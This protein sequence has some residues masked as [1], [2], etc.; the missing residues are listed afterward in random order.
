MGTAELWKKKESQ[1]KSLVMV[2][3]TVHEWM[4]MKRTKASGKYEGR[5][6][7]WSEILLQGIY[8]K[9]NDNFCTWELKH[10]KKS[11]K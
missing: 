8:T 6:E 11:K 7:K 10:I 9:D 4:L 2:S 3:N 1:R 5:Q